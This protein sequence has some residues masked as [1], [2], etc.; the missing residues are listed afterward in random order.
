MGALTPPQRRRDAVTGTAMNEVHIATDDVGAFTRR[1]R[2]RVETSHV[3][4]SARFAVRGA[5]WMKASKPTGSGAIA[6]RDRTACAVGACRQRRVGGC[7]SRQTSAA[8]L[9]RRRLRRRRALSSRDARTL[10]RRA[11]AATCNFNKFML[12]VPIYIRLSWV[13]KRACCA[14]A[15]REPRAAVAHL[16][17]E[18]IRVTAQLEEAFVAFGGVPY[19]IGLPSPSLRRRS[20]R[21][22]V[23]S[24]STLRCLPN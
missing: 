18:R 8:S 6:R 5:V 9:R 4:P 14:A 22:R 2:D 17:S 24:L 19:R 3:L 1:S 7:F 21:K 15:H 12:R 20:S 16:R 13:H 23:G 11:R 10:I